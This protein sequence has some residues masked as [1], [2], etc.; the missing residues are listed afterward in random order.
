MGGTSSR[1]ADK[2]VAETIKPRKRGKHGRPVVEVRDSGGDVLQVLSD[3]DLVLSNADAEQILLEIDKRADKSTRLLLTGAGLIEYNVHDID[4]SR[5]NLLSER[6]LKAMTDVVRSETADLVRTLSSESTRDFVFGVD[7]T[8]GK[9][10]LKSGQ[11]AVVVRAKQSSA[12]IVPKMLPVGD[13][14]ARLAGFGTLASQTAPHIVETA[15]GR[16]LILVCHDAQCFNH[17]TIARARNANATTSRQLAIDAMESQ[18][19]AAGTVP[20][21]LNLIHSVGE[22]IQTRTFATS[23]KQLAGDHH[24]RAIKG[25]IGAFCYK[26]DPSDEDLQT[27]AK[28]LRDRHKKAPIAIVRSSSTLP[29]SHPR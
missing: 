24:A 14:D 12:T 18:L 19:R 5:A 28:E 20:F 21:A 29:L 26:N 1:S 16:T 11:F 27:W 2:A 17:L 13:E 8:V 7:V 4:S 10:A 6:T 9:G 23:H 25:V 22:R 15:L 3:H